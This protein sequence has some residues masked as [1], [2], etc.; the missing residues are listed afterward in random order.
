M[1]RDV[2][3]G[4]WGSFVE[5]FGREH[6]AWLATVH[7]IDARG[8]VTRSAQKPLKSATASAGAMTLEFIGD[9]HSLSAHHPC[10]LRIQETDIGL[11]QALEIDGPEGQFIRLAFR[12]TAMPEQL[13]GLAP[14][15]LTR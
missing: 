14:G 2:P 5:R 15:E 10:A 4:E 6:H 7:A 8:T 3:I 9:A 1:I 13:D 12:A 11:V